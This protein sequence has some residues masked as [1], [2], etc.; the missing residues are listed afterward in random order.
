MNAFMCLFKSHNK[1]L[2][3][4]LFFMFSKCN[5]CSQWRGEG[6]NVCSNY[7]FHE[8]FTTRFYDVCNIILL[9]ASFPVLF[10]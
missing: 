4:R 3:G 5:F 8:E 1:K 7:Y 9:V 2:V 6:R 10:G